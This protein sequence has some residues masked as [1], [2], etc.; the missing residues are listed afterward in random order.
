[1]S[2][3]LAIFLYPDLETE[4]LH[5]NEEP[6]HTMSKS[7]INEYT[8]SSIQVPEDSIANCDLPCKPA[9]K[10]A[11]PRVKDNHQMNI[12]LSA[13]NAEMVQVQVWSEGFFSK[14]KGSTGDSQ[15]H[16]ITSISNA[17][18]NTQNNAPLTVQPPSTVPALQKPIQDKT[19]IV[20]SAPAHP[21]NIAV[22]PVDLTDP[23]RL[24]TFVPLESPPA[25]QCRHKN[26]MSVP[27]TRID[28]LEGGFWNGFPNGKFAIDLDYSTFSAHKNLAV[29]WAT[30]GSSGAN[31]KNGQ[32]FTVNGETISQGRES[33]KQCLGILR[34]RNE[35][36]DI[37]TR[38]KTHAKSLEKQTITQQCQCGASLEHFPCESRSYLIEYGQVGT[39]IS[40]CKY[41][42]INGQPHNHPRLPYVKYL[43]AQE[44]K[45]TKEHLQIN[46]DQTPL[47]SYAAG[48]DS[49]GKTKSA[50]EIGQ[51]LGNPDTFRYHRKNF[52]NS[53]KSE[54]GSSFINQF[55]S[56]IKQHRDEVIMRENTV[57]REWM[58]DQLL[59]KAV[60]IEGP[61]PLEG[62]LTDGAHKY[63]SDL[64]SVLISTTTFCPGIDRWV[65]CM[66][67]FAN[68]VTTRHYHWHFTSVIKSIF[69]AALEYDME[70]KDELF[71][72]DN[73]RTRAEL[74]KAA[75]ELIK[76]CKYH[77]EK[78]MTRV[79]RLGNHVPPES[80]DNFLETCRQMVETENS[81]VFN[82]L[83]KIMQE[84]W[85]GL[86]AWQRWWLAPEHA[87]MIFR[88]QRTMDSTL[89]SKLPDT[90]NAEESLHSVIYTIAGQN[91]DIVPGCDATTIPETP[92]RRRS[93]Q[94]HTP[95]PRKR[96]RSALREGRA[97]DTQSDLRKSKKQKHVKILALSSSGSEDEL[98][99]SPKKA[100]KEQ[101]IKIPVLD[102][103]SSKHDKIPVSKKKMSQGK[104][105][106]PDLSAPLSID[107]AIT[108]EFASYPWSRN[109]CWLDTSLHLVYIT[110]MCHGHW[111]EFASF[112]APCAGQDPTKWPISY[113]HKTLSDRRA[114]PLSTF[115]GSHSEDD[116]SQKLQNIRDRFR[117]I[118]AGLPRCLS[119]EETSYHIY[120]LYY[121]ITAPNAKRCDGPICPD[122]VRFFL[123]VIQRVSSCSEGH[124]QVGHP[125]VTNSQWQEP[126]ARDFNLFKGN[127]GNWFESLF[128]L[129]SLEV[130]QSFEECWRHHTREGTN[131][132]DIYCQGSCQKMEFVSWI[133]S[134][135]IIRPGV[136]EEGKQPDWDFPCAM[137]LDT[138]SSSKKS[139]AVYKLVGRMFSNGTH[140][141]CITLIPTTGGKSV[142]FLYDGMEHNGYAQ[143]LKGKIADLLGGKTSL[144][145]YHT[146]CS[147]YSLEGGV[148]AQ[149]KFHQDCIKTARE[150][151]DIQLDGTNSATLVKAGYRVMKVEETKRWKPHY[152]VTEYQQT[153]SDQQVIQSISPHSNASSGCPVTPSWTILSSSPPPSSPLPILCQCG[154]ENDGHRDSVKQ[155][156][157]QCDQC[158]RWS[159]LACLVN[160][161]EPTIE[162]AFICHVCSGQSLLASKRLEIRPPNC[163]QMLQDVAN[164]LYA[165]RT[166]LLQM[167]ARDKF[168]YPGRLLH[169]EKG[170]WTVK[171]WRGIKHENANKILEGIPISRIVDGLYGDREGRRAIRLGKFTRIH[172]ERDPEDVA[173]D[174]RAFPYN[175]EVDKAL[176]KH[177]ITLQE[178]LL[179]TISSD[180]SELSVECVPA[181]SLYL[182][183]IDLGYT[184]PEGYIALTSMFGHPCPSYFTGGITTD[185][186][187]RILNW[188][189]ENVAG[190]GKDFTAADFELCFAHAR[191]L[192]LAHSQRETFLEH[193]KEGSSVQE[194]ECLILQQAWQ[195]L[196]D[197]TGKTVDG[198]DKIQ[199]AD[200]DG[201][202]LMI[203]EAAMFDRS[204]KAGKA[205]RE[206]WGLD[207]DPPEDS[208]WPYDGPEKYAP[209]IQHAT[210]SDLEVK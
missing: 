131:D 143:Q 5:S 202:A 100:K 154:T 9:P 61:L 39:D 82:Q 160:R 73:T 197:F 193:V 80:R 89:A 35:N 127:I 132:P 74:E 45:D 148:N 104:E 23:A 99:S 144:S 30:W 167:T 209:D 119:G 86:E 136:S 75:Q 58:R 210:E 7:V 4:Q 103:F 85:P 155:D 190:I 33:Y 24:T 152:S 21:T 200:V 12:N 32:S 57:G 122:A 53:A 117:H 188:I 95:S 201:E 176:Y 163:T 26:D 8:N 120:W 91:K 206:Q 40:T 102:S 185:D 118:L 63:W 41:R 179:S 37:I 64:N 198:K 130:P 126:A 55:H 112:A 11:S 88:S 62:M 178:I 157:V 72:L 109:S 142:A 196:V 150:K 97:P 56:W 145:G 208:W 27:F 28:L 169:G 79:S 10:D 168:Y 129:S 121:L 98:P 182:E 78:S 52:K 128:N 29:Q 13:T 108:K 44:S 71:A 161:L 137:Y 22:Y 92:K 192:F 166:V 110:L 195:R 194:I 124:Y 138:K 181:L 81:G 20:P 84:R 6:P 38:P 69:E 189:H 114:W 76:G 36:C 165:G 2:L 90:T 133:P 54:V 111:E 116:G 205:G 135:L 83:V 141:R 59:P 19:V 43:T 65:P 60:L 105:K 184:L 42:Y 1:M 93:S 66:F 159:H 172:E 187:A 14:M 175:T 34:C 171:M 49:E 180:F 158:Q 207:V 134:V 96:D 164:R 70:I 77:F 113:L 204:A 140:F 48:K 191:T 153:D 16:H 123:P 18:H 149:K 87:S 67:S 94:S 17:G 50:R 106:R 51:C 15:L 146:V 125:R 170:K 162:G 177:K 199:R 115:A 25:P 186:R 151:L 174:W 46:Q 68:G 173:T 3:K 31:G 147:F 47:Q 156:T 107:L 101:Q 139:G 183:D 203:L